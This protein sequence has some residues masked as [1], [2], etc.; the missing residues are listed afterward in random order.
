M[1]HAVNGSKISLQSEGG[2]ARGV[3]VLGHD[4]LYTDEISGCPQ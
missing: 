4:Q 3:A 2:H 1:A